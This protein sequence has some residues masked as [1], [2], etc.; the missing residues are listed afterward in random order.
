MLITKICIH[1]LSFDGF[2]S[3]ELSGVVVIDNNWPQF[4]I[5]TYFGL[6]M[7]SQCFRNSFCILSNQL[8]TDISKSFNAVYRDVLSSDA[9]QVYSLCGTVSERHMFA[10]VRSVTVK[11]QNRF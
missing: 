7:Q 4:C 10:D 1:T 9:E 3:P 11:V 2:K 8:E 6:F 5:Y